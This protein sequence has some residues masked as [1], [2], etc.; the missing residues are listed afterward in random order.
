MDQEGVDRER[1]LRQ[2]KEKL[3][4]RCT[5][6]SLEKEDPQAFYEEAALCG[7]EALNAYLEEGVISD[8]RIAGMIADRQIF[9]CYFGSALK[10][11]GIDEFLEGIRRL[12]VC[13]QYPAEFGARV[14]KITRDGQGNRLTFMKITGGSLKVRDILEGK[15]KESKE[16]ESWQEKVSQIRV[17]SGAKFQT[18]SQVEAGTVCAVVGLSLIHI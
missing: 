5:D 8:Q 1:L 10:V 16:E 17:Y 13:P 14:F 15:E 6:F 11:W 3:D 4:E 9:P 7:E 12:A 2:R 18:V